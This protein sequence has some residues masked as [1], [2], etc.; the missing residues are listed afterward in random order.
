MSEE[1]DNQRSLE[2]GAAVQRPRRP[3]R[4]F[5]RRHNGPRARGPEEQRGDLN[6]PA[7]RD[8]QVAAER[9][10][11]ANSGGSESDQRDYQQRSA[12]GNDP[13]LG[14]D[15]GPSPNGETQREPEFGDGIIEI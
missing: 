2:T 5:P 7:D 12:Q 3:R 8:D 10:G 13:S 11:I 9:V 14:T 15:G 4:R 6:G 1:T